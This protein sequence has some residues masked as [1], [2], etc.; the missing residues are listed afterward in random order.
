MSRVMD[1][2]GEVMFWLR[3]DY[4]CCATFGKW[5]QGQRSESL[6][7]FNKISGDPRNVPGIVVDDIE[8]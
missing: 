7:L 6:I 1:V 4:L 5:E 8:K 2:N 3:G